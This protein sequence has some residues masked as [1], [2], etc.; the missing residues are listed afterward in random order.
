MQDE[1]TAAAAS[2]LRRFR[3]LRTTD[4]ARRAT[5]RFAGFSSCCYLI[6]SHL[7]DLVG[8]IFPNPDFNLLTDLCREHACMIRLALGH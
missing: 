2:A 5:R 1:K 6:D 3:A 8:M 7:S 4:T